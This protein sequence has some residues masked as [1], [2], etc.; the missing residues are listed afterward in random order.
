[1]ATVDE[2]LE[3]V[4][5]LSMILGGRFAYTEGEFYSDVE[6]IESTLEAVKCREQSKDAAKALAKL[7]SSA[8]CDDSRSVA[9][10]LQISQPIEK[11]LELVETLR[12]Y[13]TEITILLRKI[14][15]DVD[16]IE[17]AESIL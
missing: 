7:Q 10:V 14:A 4:R 12:K 6:T 1:M 5:R 3:A 2:A 9:D 8:V 16:D 15:D 11:E 17:L 13:K